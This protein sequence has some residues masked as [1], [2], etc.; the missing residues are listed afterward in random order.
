MEVLT[1]E[2][3]KK[4]S[5]FGIRTANPLAGTSPSAL[6]FGGEQQNILGRGNSIIP[7]D[8]ARPQKLIPEIGIVAGSNPTNGSLGL[9]RQTVSQPDTAKPLVTASVAPPAIAKAAQPVTAS[10]S[11]PIAAGARPAANIPVTNGSTQPIGARPISGIIDDNKIN[12]IQDPSTPQRTA[13]VSAENVAVNTPSTD[14]TQNQFGVIAKDLAAQSQ[15][16]IQRR[17]STGIA[18]DGTSLSQGANAIGAGLVSRGLANR[19]KTFSDLAAQQAG[20]NTSQQNANT[21]EFGARSGAAERLKESA[22]QESELGLRRNA[23]KVDVA[24]K[25]LALDDFIRLNDLKTKFLSEKDPVQKKILA[26]RLATLQ[27]KPQQKFQIASIKGV[28]EKT[29]LPTEAP[30]IIDEAGN[31]RA[32]TPP[33]TQI[34][35]VGNN[36]A[37]NIKQQVQDGKITREQAILQ[38]K[39]LGF[40]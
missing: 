18:E 17:A 8:G 11:Q 24:G 39:K 22:R 5:G 25:Q 7:A 9:V 13:P 2:Q 29:G 1:E 14:N 23:N 40:N 12:A 15:E 34:S 27:G 19:A 10:I 37:E 6:S 3:K 20:V 21:N 38:L 35:N 30:F 33:P 32:I 26:D 31:A 28:D 4:Q 16:L 36:T